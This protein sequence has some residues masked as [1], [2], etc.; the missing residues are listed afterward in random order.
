MRLKASANLCLSVM[1]LVSASAYAHPPVQPRI[2]FAAP[3]SDDSGKN[4]VLLGSFKP[5][6]NVTLLK[7]KQICKATTGATIPYETFGKRNKATKL[8]GLQECPKKPLIAIVGDAAESVQLSVPKKN[9]TPLPKWVARKARRLVA[10]KEPLD[11]YDRLSSSPHKILKVGD[12]TLLQFAWKMRFQGNA[13]NGPKV[14][15]AHNQFFVMGD[16][17]PWGHVFFIVNNKPHLA[18][19]DGECNSGGWWWAVY[20][21]SGKKPREVYANDDMAT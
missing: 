5:G 2:Y 8:V 19:I 11:D 17:C 6:L 1:L 14:L 16:S 9:P 4:L 7:E 21:L 13:D 20:D 3:V 15:F 18:F 10:P 12:F